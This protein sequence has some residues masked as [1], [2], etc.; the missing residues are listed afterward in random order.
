MVYGDE[1][2]ATPDDVDS[3]LDFVDGFNFKLEKAGGN[4]IY[5]KIY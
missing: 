1:S 4:K 2:V 3:L 5:K